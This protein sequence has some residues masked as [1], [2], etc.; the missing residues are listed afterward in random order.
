MMKNLF[1]YLLIAVAL[2]A[3]SQNKNPDGLHVVNDF[4]TY[5][6]TVAKNPEMELVEVQKAIPSV[7]LDVRYATENNFMKQVMYPQ[8][9]VFARK[10]VVEKLKLVQADLNKLGYGLLI[11]DGYRPYA[12]T[13]DF[14]EK[15]DDNARDNGYVADPKKGSK[16]NRGCA[17][18]LTLVDLKTG[19]EVP[20]PTPYDSFEA[21]A[22]ADYS[23]LPE[24]LIKNRAILINAMEA[25]DFKVLPHEWWHFDFKDWEKYDLM[26][27]PFEKL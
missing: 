20:M 15:S 25:H 11:F 5:Q 19:K 1:G 22:A 8:P 27:I 26:D 21:S 10:P 3:C 23:D 9:R 17:I 12:V 14:Y 2:S 6:A 16:H 18:D 13:V 24:E 4:E 7:V